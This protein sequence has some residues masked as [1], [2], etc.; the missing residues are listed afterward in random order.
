MYLN[1]QGNYT[2]LRKWVF[3]SSTEWAIFGNSSLRWVN[4]WLYSFTTIH[5]LKQYKNNKNREFLERKTLWV[6]FS[7]TLYLQREPRDHIPALALPIST[8]QV[9]ELQRGY[10]A[11]MQWVEAGDVSAQLSP[12]PMLSFLMKNT[13]AIRRRTFW[14]STPSFNFI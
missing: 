12:Y 3:Q 4:T 11:L 13:K 9:V 6:F 8:S 2:S 7:F 14:L 10:H 5:G 1:M